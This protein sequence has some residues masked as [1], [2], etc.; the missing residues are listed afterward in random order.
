MICQGFV[1]EERPAEAFC[2]LSARSPRLRARLRLRTARAG[3]VIDL[4]RAILDTPDR[5]PS[6]PCPMLRAASSPSRSAAGI[7]LPCSVPSLR[8]RRRPAA[9]LA[10]QAIRWG[11]TSASRTLLAPDDPREPRRRGLVASLLAGVTLE[12]VGLPDAPPLSASRPAGPPHLVAPAFLEAALVQAGLPD[13]RIRTV[14][15]HRPPLRFGGKGSS[16]AGSPMSSPSA[17]GHASAVRAER[18]GASSSRSARADP[19]RRRSSTSGARTTARSLSPAP[20]PRSCRSSAARRRR[21]FPRRR[22]SGPRADLFAGIRDGG[23]DP[24]PSTGNLCRGRVE[25]GR[26]PARLVPDG[27]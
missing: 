5:P 1:A 4:D 14:L 24:V 17:N 16:A 10:T 3:G 6:R 11:R 13:P 21:R 20:P 26:R 2:R 9:F 7:Q 12:C 25:A 18:T 19:P 23:A 22:R 8:P 27:A 15:V